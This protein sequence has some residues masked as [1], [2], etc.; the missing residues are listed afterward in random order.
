MLQI[1]PTQSEKSL[2]PVPDHVSII[3]DGNGRWAEKHSLPRLDGHKKGRD[4]AEKIIS[5]AAEIGIKTLTLYAF[6]TENWRRSKS[7]VNGLLLLLKDVLVT[8]VARLKQENIKLRVIGDISPLSYG[9]R[10]SISKA[11]EA[12]KDCTKMTLQ[13]ALN[14]GARQEIVMTVKNIVSA[15][16]RGDFSIEDID[17]QKISE[18]LY[19]HGVSD[20][21][22]I[23]RT[24]GEQRLSNFLLW[25][26]SYAELRF[27]TTLWPDFTVQ[28]FRSIID[29]YRN[30]ER[31]YGHAHS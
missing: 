20:P 25:Q 17:E 21:D 7:E 16:V 30:R 18:N 24:S 12:T 28:E 26:S 19:T 22:L 3:M 11:I 27:V 1:V 8:E 23:I 2:L 15:A 29:D 4:I 6:S 31:R 5:C 14:Y 13:I 10:A 9:L